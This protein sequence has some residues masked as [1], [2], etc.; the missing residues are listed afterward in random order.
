MRFA[1]QSHKKS[2]IKM[3]FPLCFSLFVHFL[4]R[5]VLRTGMPLK[6]GSSVSLPSDAT[7]KDHHP[8]KRKQPQSFDEQP[9]GSTP[10]TAPGTAPPGHDDVKLS[11]N[12][13]KNRLIRSNDLLT[14]T[15]TEVLLDLLKQFAGVKECSEETQVHL[16]MVSVGRVLERILL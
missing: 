7:T 14:Q 16:Y 4:N 12:L 5:L 1:A 3:S 13:E 6:K 2:I 8:L 10:T 15:S 11:C 9:T